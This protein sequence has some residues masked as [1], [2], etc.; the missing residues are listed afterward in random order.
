MVIIGAGMAGHRAVI[1]LRA[2]GHDG[3]ITVIGEEAWMPYDRPPLS[4]SA[5]TAEEEPLPVWL[6]DDDIAKSLKAEARCGV[7]V[8]H[9]DPAARSIRLSDGN[10]LSYSKLLLATGAKPRRLSVPGGENAWTLRNFD[11]A[12]ALRKAFKPGRRIVLIGAG[13]IGLELAASAVKR[14]CHVTVIEA[15]PRILMRGVPERIAKIV[16]ARHE[17]AGVDLIV[18]TGIASIGPRSVNLSDGRKIEADTV[19]AGIGAAPDT[20]LAEAA[21][22]AIDNGIAVDATLRTSDPHIYAAGD[23]CSF[24][25]ALFGDTR[26]RLEAWRNAQ[27]QGSHAAENMM[28]ADK[29]Y[30]AVPWFWSDQYE[31]S[32][33]IAGLPAHGTDIV[34]RKPGPDSLLLF[35]L[36]RDGRLVGASGI[37]PGNSIA[38]D[39]KLAEMLIAKNARPDAAQLADA[40]VALKSL[41]KG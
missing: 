18:G 41:L 15:Q 29:P 1:G 24:P 39:I 27:V 28:G 30:Q 35:H 32:L 19:V 16:H 13:F 17:A 10:T 26:I 38:R 8:A 11:D 7:S 31:L 36:D 37:G 23:C 34:E 2:S 40:S 25:H 22:L 20:H 6:M 5:L 14:G 4:K 21:G 12:L 33:Q 9:I 3:P